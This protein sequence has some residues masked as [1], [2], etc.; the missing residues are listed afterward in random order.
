MQSTRSGK[1]FQRTMANISTFK[2]IHDALVEQSLILEVLLLVMIAP[3][4]LHFHIIFYVQFSSKMHMIAIL[5]QN[6][7]LLITL[8]IILIVTFFYLQNELEFKK[9][10]TLEAQADIVEQ[11][12]HRPKLRFQGIPDSGDGEGTDSMN[13]KLINDLRAHEF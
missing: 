2:E 10:V 4:Y 9:V 8:L 3:G 13:I 5:A 6:Y 1:Q 11:Y 12:S 7:I